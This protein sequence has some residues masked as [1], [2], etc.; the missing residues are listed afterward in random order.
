MNF[1]TEGFSISTNKIK[2]D[3]ELICTFLS[4]AYWANQRTRDTI[5]KS[6]EHSLCFGLFHLESQIGL[7][8]VVT[9]YATF[10]YLCD[11]FVLE[12]YQGRGLGKWL[13]DHVMAHSELTHLRRFMLATRDAHGLY[14][15]FGFEALNAP[16]RWM[17]RFNKSA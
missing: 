12:D 13:M 15:Q 6:L 4:S 14:R 2:L 17:E 8:R 3:L 5:A 10:V 11:V 7:A 16:D 1:E 9:D